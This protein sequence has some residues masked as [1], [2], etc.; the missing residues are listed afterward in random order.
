MKRLKSY[1][2]IIVLFSGSQPVSS[3]IVARPFS[4]LGFE[5]R[6]TDAVNAIRLIDTHEHL[7][8]EK[9]ALA[10]VADFSTLFI[11]YQLEDLISSGAPSDQLYSVFKS[12]DKSLE[13][14]WDVFKNY[15]ANTR[16]TGYGRTVLI[17]A[18][19]LYG[20]DD[21][22]ENTY[23]ELSKR[24]K[25]SHKEK[26]YET[27]LK[28]KAKIDAS[29]IMEYN[30]VTPRDVR[31]EGNC[32]FRSFFVYDKFVTIFGYDRMNT[33]VAQYGLKF[34][35]LR[36]LESVI[37]TVFYHDVKKGIQGIKFGVAYSRTLKFDEVSKETANAVLEKMK[38]DPQRL[39]TFEEAKPLQ[40]Y[41]FFKVLSLCEKY[42]LPVQIHTG[43][44]TG[45]GNDITNSNPTGLVKAF[46]K[47]PKLK[48]V[49]LHAGYPY[50]GEMATIAKTFANVYIDMAWSAMISPSYTIRNLE[51]YIETVPANKI[52]CYGGDCQ[53][54]EGA[55][56]ASILARET[57]SAALNDKVKTGYLTEDEAI[58]IA[59]KVLR[60]NALSI[61]NIK[62]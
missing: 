58:S 57:V 40:D 42:N 7:M 24:I 27:V 32:N 16:S 50:G 12:K 47:F 26:Y 28:E 5:K 23:K 19:D 39:L 54:V 13:E 49:L 11:N 17:T 56:G 1:L 36:E 34:T 21:I 43:L 35:S 52:M 31:N 60:E 33:R 37:D 51:E 61:Y 9:E 38:S 48:F 30:T 45:T 6:I 18:K 3:Q 2:L 29:I 15:W 22:N 8:S 4:K 20:I 46:F 44:Q 41:L 14:K 55:Y 59:K 10:G 25:D 53:N 62:F